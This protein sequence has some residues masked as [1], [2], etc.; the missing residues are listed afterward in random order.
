MIEIAFHRSTSRGR[1]WAKSKWR[2]LYRALALSTRVDWG[3]VLLSALWSDLDVRHRSSPV[4]GARVTFVVWRRTG[5]SLRSKAVRPPS[6]ERGRAYT[7]RALA[8]R[9]APAPAHRLPL[10]AIGLVSSSLTAALQRLVSR[11]RAA[12]TRVTPGDSARGVATDR[13]SRGEASAR[14]AAKAALAEAARRTAAEPGK[15][16]D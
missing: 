7:A 6:F 13:L 8:L 16:S 2:R 4:V 12:T 11:L 1:V 5:C 14:A 10:R 15:H 3:H 9:I